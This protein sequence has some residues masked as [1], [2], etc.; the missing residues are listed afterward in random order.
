MCDSSC[1]GYHAGRGTAAMAQS[2]VPD[3]LDGLDAE[4]LSEVALGLLALTI[5]DDCRAWKGLDWRVMDLLHARGWIEDPR[6]KA[7]SVVM[8]EDGLALAEKFLLKHFER[9]TK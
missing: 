6:N 5:H 3:Q 1:E 7:K 8:T 9:Q 4:K 2:P